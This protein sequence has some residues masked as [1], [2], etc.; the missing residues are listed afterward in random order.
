MSKG[1][2]YLIQPCE[3]VGTNRYKI[4]CS[5]SPNL[6]RCK[7]GYNKGSRFICI[8]ECDNPLVLEKNIK[9]K[10][11]K[12]FKLISGTEYF[13]GDEKDMLK[14]FI[15]IINLYEKSNNIIINT[16]LNCNICNKKYKTYQTLW[17]HN[18]I[19]H[20]DLIIHI[21]QNNKECKF[22]CEL[23]NKKFTRNN[24]LKYHKNNTCKIKNNNIN[25]LESDIIEDL[26]LFENQ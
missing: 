12:L 24:N 8:M 13:G 7:N 16:T 26:F 15:E 23:C 19:K 3:L 1:I 10:F 2:L 14:E 6:D 9:E 17:K 25:I 20:S 21:K 22:C 18:K 4:G 11:N 5:K